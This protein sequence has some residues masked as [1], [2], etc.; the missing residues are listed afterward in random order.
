MKRR[1]YFY[2][3]LGLAIILS[4]CESS[5]TTTFLGDFNDLSKD[6]Q[7]VKTKNA[8]NF[9]R[10][11]YYGTWNGQIVDGQRV[12]NTSIRIDKTYFEDIST[13]IKVKY[14]FNKKTNEI[15]L[16]NEELDTI[17]NTE[18]SDGCLV[19][20]F[21]DGSDLNI[22]HEEGSFLDKNGEKSLSMGI[23]YNKVLP[24]DDNEDMQVEPKDSD[25]TGL[26]GGSI[27]SASS[28]SNSLIEQSNT[29]QNPM[30]GSWTTSETPMV[31]SIDSEL[32]TIKHGLETYEL[33][34][35]II[36]EQTVEY[37]C[38]FRIGDS[39]RIFKVELEHVSP[40]GGTAKLYL[41]DQRVIT[42]YLYLEQ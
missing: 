21:A 22:L 37:E 42:E 8:K 39:A 7:N 13:G 20:S 11:D 12:N 25:T 27:E 36:N 23:T 14:K 33:T 10:E 30:I 9:D 3:L 35:P 28:D 2:M 19:Y 31:F 6:F 5:T 18:L 16:E 1:F 40:D 4:G 26:S 32:A 24:D 29:E 15:V 34:N 17:L 38:D 41:E